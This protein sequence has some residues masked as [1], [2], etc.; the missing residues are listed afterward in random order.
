M[1]LSCPAISSDMTGDG[2]S[3]ISDLWPTLSAIYHWPGNCIVEAVSQ[4]AQLANF[5]ELDQ[6]SC[7]GW[8]AASLSAAVWLALLFALTA[9]DVMLD[10]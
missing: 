7:S 8:L 4:N 5:L 1:A 9:I 3:T 10:R 2:R 6:G